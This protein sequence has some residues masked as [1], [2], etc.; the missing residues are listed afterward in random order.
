MHAGN[1]AAEQAFK[2]TIEGTEMA[3]KIV[4]SGMKHIAAALYVLLKDNNK[5]RGALRLKTMMKQNPN[6]VVYS[7]RKEDMQQFVRSAKDYGILYCALKDRNKDG[8]ID[9]LVRPEDAGRIDRIVQRFQLNAVSTDTRISVE[10]EPTAAPTPTPEAQAQETR[11]TEDLLNSLLGEQPIPQPE[12]E[13][14]SLLD[15]LMEP[16]AKEETPENPTMAETGKSPLSEPF[17]EKSA[18]GRTGDDG[19][20]SVRQD[21]R[22]IAAQ[23]KNVPKQGKNKRMER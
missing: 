7:V 13:A 17:S 1:D 2:L 16:K 20:K 19:R 11:Q 12:Q 15:Y 6:A 5:T 10:Q 8:L 23:Q 14:Q 21:L 9:V 3:V 18:A 22:T 4:G